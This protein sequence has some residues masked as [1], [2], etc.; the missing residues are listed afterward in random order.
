M[1]KLSIYVIHSRKLNYK[2]EF[3]KPLLLSECANHNLI[4]PLTEKYQE[5]YAKDLVDNSDVIIT[6]LTD[7]TFSVFLETRWAIKAKKTILFLI[8][9]KSKCSFLLK[10]YKK[11]SE[12]Y[13]NIVEEKDIINRFLNENMANLTSK[14]DSGVINLGSIS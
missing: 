2:E 8:K 4:L 11:R 10:K 7:S 14:D 1:K 6:N 9:D 12:T 13:L 5:M 3:Y